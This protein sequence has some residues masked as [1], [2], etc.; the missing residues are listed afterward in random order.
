MQTPLG[1][2]WAFSSSRMGI[3]F[4]VLVSRPSPWFP[5]LSCHSQ[6]KAGT[7]V[8]AVGTLLENP[9]LDASLCVAICQNRARE[10][11]AASS[12]VFP[13]FCPG[14]SG[15]PIKVEIYICHTYFN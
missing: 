15:F 5:S 12:V 14:K 4:G 6:H 3:A 2:R 9:S 1:L 13:S 11:V 10:A 7:A 8:K